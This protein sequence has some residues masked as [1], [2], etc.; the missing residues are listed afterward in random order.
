LAQG[1][2]TFAE[3]KAA[4][5]KAAKRPAVW[6]VQQGFGGAQCPIKIYR[7]I[8]KAKTYQFNLRGYGQ[9]VYRVQLII[10]AEGSQPISGSCKKHDIDTD[11]ED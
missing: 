7:S 3:A 5:E 9:V 1:Y 6:R 2:R 8:R 11:D 10:D 4:A